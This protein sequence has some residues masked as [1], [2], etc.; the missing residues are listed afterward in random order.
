LEGGGLP[1]YWEKPNALTVSRPDGKEKG[2]VGKAPSKKLRGE[3]KKRI[4]LKRM[5]AP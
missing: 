4:L 3:G 5:A 2:G 1:Y